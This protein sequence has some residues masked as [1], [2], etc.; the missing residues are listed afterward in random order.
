MAKLKDIVHHPCNIWT[1]WDPDSRY[2]LLLEGRGLRDSVIVGKF[3]SYVKTEREALALVERRG[4][5][6]EYEQNRD[7]PSKQR[8]DINAVNDAYMELVYGTR[9]SYCRRRRIS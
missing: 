8:P 1:A 4:C 3:K 2:W 9:R 5:E 6:Y 7:K